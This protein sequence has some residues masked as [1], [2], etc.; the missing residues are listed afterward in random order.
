MAGAGVKVRRR[1]LAAAVA[2]GAVVGSGLVGAGP[3]PTAVAEPVNSCHSR[4]NGDPSLNQ[5]TLS[6]QTLDVRQASK[7]LKV[8]ALVSDDNGQPGPSSKVAGVTVSIESQT[9]PSK[10]FF[11]SLRRTQTNK[12]KWAGMQVFPEWTAQGDWQVVSVFI[13]DHANNF[14]T[15]SYDDLNN[16]IYDRDVTVDSVPDTTPP[17]V[18]SFAISPKIVKAT[19]RPRRVTFTATASDSQS[20]VRYVLASVAAGGLTQSTALTK[21]KGNPHTY[22]G[23]LAIS[24][25]QGSAR[26]HLQ[27][28]FGYD[29][30]GNN[31]EYDANF[32]ALGFDHRFRV[33]SGVDGAAPRVAHLH[34]STR[35]VDVRNKAR[36]IS[37]GLAAKD[38]KSGSSSADVELIGPNDSLVNQSFLHRHGSARHATFSGSMHLRPCSTPAGRFKVL[39]VVTDLA[40]NQ[41]RIKDGVVSVKAKDHVAPTATIPAGAVPVNGPLEVDF[42]ENVERDLRRRGPRASV[43]VDGRG[44]RHVG[45]H[46]RGCAGDRLHD[47]QGTD[48]HLHTDGGDDAVVVVRD[49]DQP[50]GNPRC[51]GSERQPVPPLAGLVRDVVDQPTVANDPPTADR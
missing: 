8:S 42:D 43:R 40:G 19:A 11:V 30:I 45:V 3:V 48:G 21:V 20:G 47:G 51:H 23:S 28:V 16:P 29:N 13:R 39:V 2:T 35:A 22:R 32:G 27:A 6:P 10:E 15:Y 1:G 33:V 37:F 25:W 46:G 38:L 17:T 34:L 24:R 14:A 5:L 49:R 31:V 41:V 36:S 9:D 12:F 4:D 44:P 26:W 50:R 7:T 18:S